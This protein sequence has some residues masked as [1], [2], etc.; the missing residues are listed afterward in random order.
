MAVKSVTRTQVIPYIF[1][2]DVPAALEWLSRAFGFT[3]RMRTQTPRGGTHGEML[4]G[5]QLIMMGQG[6]SQLRIK[7]SATRRS[8]R[9]AFSSTSPMWTRTMSAPAPPGRKST[10]RPKICLTGAAMRSAISRDIRGSSP[11]RPAKTDRK[12]STPR[13]APGLSRR[14]GTPAAPRRR[15]GFSGA[16]R[17]A[18]R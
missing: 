5:G 4:V 12:L 14:L 8:R 11:R 15:G 9:R 7:A 3:E 18:M 17:V 16:A 13:R 1:Y 6:S 10:S 2:R